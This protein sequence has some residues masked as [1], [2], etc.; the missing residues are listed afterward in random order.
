MCLATD[1]C[2]N[3]KLQQCYLRVLHHLR[4]I[5]N[6]LL[7][8]LLAQSDHIVIEVSVALLTNQVCANALFKRSTGQYGF[9][10]IAFPSKLLLNPAL[11]EIHVM[12]LLRAWCGVAR[13]CSHSRQLCRACCLCLW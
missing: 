4:Y 7:L 8:E 10:Q 12:S 6:I 1:G 9:A 13:E 3:H 2:Y 11:L 5:Q